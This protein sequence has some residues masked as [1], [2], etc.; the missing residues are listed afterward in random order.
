MHE[1]F[2]VSEFNFD[3]I[4]NRLRE[5]S[6]LNRGI[7]VVLYDERTEK[8]QDFHSEGGLK[9]FVEYLN[10]AK[11]KIHGDVIYFYAE[12]TGIFL[13]V[14]MQW[15]DGYKE[16]VFTFANNINTIEGGTHL[17]GFKAALTKCVNKYIEA[18]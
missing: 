9:S 6:F 17:A 12:A 13:E 18:Q 16:N 10:R 5:L 1:V 4:S 8:T 2:E 14:A 15:N 11:T 7:H 3:T